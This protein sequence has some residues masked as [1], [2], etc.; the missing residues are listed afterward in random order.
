MTIR[1]GPDGALY[2]AVHS[3]RLV[4]IAPQTPVA[5]RRACTK[6]A[7]CDDGDACTVDTCDGAVGA[8]VRTRVTPCG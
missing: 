5:C 4:R 7:E 3:G 6:D 2:V 1:T 8:C